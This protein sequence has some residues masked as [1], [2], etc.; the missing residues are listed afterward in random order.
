MVP[1][2]I[3]CHNAKYI[4]VLTLETQFFYLQDKVTVFIQHIAEN[5]FIM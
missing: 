1:Y 3:W 4:Y 2:I 5:S